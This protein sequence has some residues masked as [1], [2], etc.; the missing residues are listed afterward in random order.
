VKALNYGRREVLV[1]FR[2][3]GGSINPGAE[4]I[5][6]YDADLFSANE[7]TLLRIM[8]EEEID[9]R[10]RNKSTVLL[11]SRFGGGSPGRRIRNAC[12]FFKN[13]QGL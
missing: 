4:A 8:R 10:K 11:Y 3:G 5:E 13:T 7:T 9:T 6:R 12:R 2:Q 1:M